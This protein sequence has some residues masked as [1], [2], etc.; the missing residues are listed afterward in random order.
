MNCS[1][2][3]RTIANASQQGYMDYNIAANADNGTRNLSFERSQTKSSQRKSETDKTK[4]KTIYF[5]KNIEEQLAE[6]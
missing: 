2:N 1:K 6:G 3:I 5:Y 4:S